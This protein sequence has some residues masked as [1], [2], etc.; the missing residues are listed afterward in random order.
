MKTSHFLLGLAPVILALAG[1]RS[2]HAIA[3]ATSADAAKPVE[4]CAWRSDDEWRNALT[5]QQYAILREA[6]TEAPFRNAYWNHHEKGT[7]HCAGC[8]LELFASGTKFES[9]SGWP[10]FWQPLAT[11]RVRKRT[12]VSHGLQRT[13]IICARCEGHLGH[14]FDDGPKPSGLRYCLNSAALNFT[15]VKP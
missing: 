15:P 7:Y 14:V 2:E 12:D 8:G 9:G 4:G 10:S 5:P 13:E 11:D 1:C 3:R 6:K